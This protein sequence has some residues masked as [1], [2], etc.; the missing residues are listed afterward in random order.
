MQEVEE[1][2]VSAAHVGSVAAGQTCAS[3][4]GELKTRRVGCAGPGEALVRFVAE[5]PVVRAQLGSAW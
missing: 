3:E 4:V 5:V 1:G 2:R